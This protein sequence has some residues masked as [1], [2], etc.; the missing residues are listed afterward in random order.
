MLSFLTEKVIVIEVTIW[1][2]FDAAKSVTRSC[3]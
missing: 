2:S 1:L 3:A